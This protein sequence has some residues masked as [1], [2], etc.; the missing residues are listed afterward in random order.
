MVDGLRKLM[1]CH[2]S[3]WRYSHLNE[4]H[5]RQKFPPQ[6]IR[7]SFPNR[8]FTTSGDAHNNEEVCFRT[9]IYFAS[10]TKRDRKYFSED[11]C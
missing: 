9:N 4:S 3:F 11:V 8:S 1:E 7:K 5:Q 6:S 2:L 10:K